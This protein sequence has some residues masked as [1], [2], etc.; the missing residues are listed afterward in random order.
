MLVLKVLRQKNLKEISIDKINFVEKYLEP[1]DTRTIR[2]E[3]P[4]FFWK[5]FYLD[6]WENTGWPMINWFGN[7]LTFYDI[8]DGDRVYELVNSLRNRQGN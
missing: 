7:P 5:L 4:S 3:K 2:F 8:K 6:R 1:K